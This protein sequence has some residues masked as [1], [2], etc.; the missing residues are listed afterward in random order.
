MS[1]TSILEI[2][3]YYFVNS[4]VTVSALIFLYTPQTQT[5]SISILKLDEI[6]YIGPSVYGSIS[7]FNKY[8]SK[9]FVRICNK[10]IKN[11]TQKWQKD[12]A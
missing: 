5:A 11:N 4:M 2:V 9:T 7:A 3:V 1:I 10:E 12:V 8:N 6:G